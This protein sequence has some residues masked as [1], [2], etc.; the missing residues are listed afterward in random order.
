M[1]VSADNVG[2]PKQCFMDYM[3][4]WEEDESVRDF[5]CVKGFLNC[6]INET[7]NEL[8]EDGIYCVKLIVSKP[9]YLFLMND[10][11]L[12]HIIQQSKVL[13]CIC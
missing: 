9:M 7:Q 10:C 11:F 4:L 13:S 5:S 2:N 8:V 1:N 6:C 3:T 12:I